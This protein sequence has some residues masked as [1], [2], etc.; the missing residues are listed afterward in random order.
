MKGDGLRRPGLGFLDIRTV[1]RIGSIGL[2]KGTESSCL[3][4]LQ[5]FRGVLPTRIGASAIYDFPVITRRLL[6]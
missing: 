5:R 6:V 3:F 4:S 2:T 1:I